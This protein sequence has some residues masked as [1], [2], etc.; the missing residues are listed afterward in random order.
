[1]TANATVD[2]TGL[3]TVNVRMI[4]T[5]G[6]AHTLTLNNLQ[7]G[8]LVNIDFANTTGA[9]STPKIAGTDQSGTTIAGFAT[10]TAGTTIDLVATG[11]AITTGLTFYIQGGLILETATP[12]LQTTVIG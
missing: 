10:G 1:M 6:A 11:L 9:N 2:C 12:T 5:A 3:L 4:A 8:A 7:Q